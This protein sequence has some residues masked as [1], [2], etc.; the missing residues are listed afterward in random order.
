MILCT[1]S[2]QIEFFS[3]SSL[4]FHLV[5]FF[6]FFHIFRNNF[7][8]QK[9]LALK[10][11]DF[12]LSHLGAHFKTLFAKIGGT[13]PKLRNFLHSMHVGPKKAQNCDFVYKINAN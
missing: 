10:F 11:H 1:K 9:T 13:V 2:M 7:L 4:F 8:T 6:H 5:H 3:L 12:F